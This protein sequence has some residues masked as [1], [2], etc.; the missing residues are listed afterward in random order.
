MCANISR[1]KHIGQKQTTT[2]M[3]FIWCDDLYS[4]KRPEL[5]EDVSCNFF[6]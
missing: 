6:R 1:K 2:L 4:S 5:Y 3:S